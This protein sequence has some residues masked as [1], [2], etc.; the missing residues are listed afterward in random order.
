[1]PEPLL[2]MSR[3]ALREVAHRWF[4][5]GFKCSGPELNGETHDV[6][7]DATIRDL[8]LAEVDRLFDESLKVV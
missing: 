2:T 8:L 3:A 4:L 5:H 7:C 1:M 6:D